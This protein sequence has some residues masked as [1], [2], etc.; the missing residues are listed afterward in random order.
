MESEILLAMFGKILEAETALYWHKVLTLESI[1]GICMDGPLQRSVFSIFDGKK[2]SEV[3]KETIQSVVAMLFEEKKGLLAGLPPSAGG[4]PDAKE[5]KDGG[6][7]SFYWVQS[8]IKVPW[9][10]L[11]LLV[12]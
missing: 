12:M 1:R 5:S 6:E 2:H 11:L 7:Y 4:A 9:Y 8:G 3:F 10:I